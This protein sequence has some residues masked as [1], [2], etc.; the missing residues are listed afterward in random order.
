[1]G[2]YSKYKYEKASKMYNPS[3]PCGHEK[4]QQLHRNKNNHLQFSVYL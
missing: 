1:M 4:Y 2:N 3:H